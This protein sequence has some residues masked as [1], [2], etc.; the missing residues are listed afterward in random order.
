MAKP[1]DDRAWL[2]VL[3]VVA[4]VAR[5]PLGGTRDSRHRSKGN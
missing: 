1:R 3:P 2:L 4:L 5:A